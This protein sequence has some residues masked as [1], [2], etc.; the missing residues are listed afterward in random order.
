MIFFVYKHINI[1]HQNI[2]GLL[3]KVDELTVHLYTLGE[4]INCNPVDLLCITEHNM[5]AEDAQLLKMPNFTLGDC[6]SRSNRN[7]G[8]CIIIK[9]S[10]KFKIVTEAKSL[11]ISN[12]FE[13]SGI[14][15]IDHKIIILCIY[16][17]PK[18]GKE[19]IDF[20]FY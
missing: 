17:P 9:S 19:Y 13:C 16:R 6:F 14:E 3:T 8:S 7:G 18:N 12:L 4:N 5:T 10:L 20:F 2:N 15:L 11:S 1:L